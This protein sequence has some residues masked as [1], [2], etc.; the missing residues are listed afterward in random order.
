[1][2]FFKQQALRHMLY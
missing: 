1:V 2:S